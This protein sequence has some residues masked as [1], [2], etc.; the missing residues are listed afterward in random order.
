ME[1]LP[2]SVKPPAVIF[3]DNEQDTNDVAFDFSTFGLNVAVH[4]HASS[5]STF[6]SSQKGVVKVSV[7]KRWVSND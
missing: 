2:A 1:D 3:S 6:Q 7:N 4:T 5:S